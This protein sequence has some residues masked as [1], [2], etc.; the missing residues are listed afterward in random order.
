MARHLLE[1][2]DLFVASSGPGSASPGR[3]RLRTLVV[4]RWIAVIGQMFSLLLVRYGLG[5]ELPILPCAITVLASA[6]LNGI[7]AIQYPTTARLSN[8]GATL[9]LAYDLLQLCALLYMTG[10]LTNPFAILILVPVVISATILSAGSTFLLGAL[11]LLFSIL[12]AFWHLP[13]PWAPDRLDLP[14]LYRSAIWTGL[15]LGIV[16]MSVYAGRVAFETRRMSDALMATHEALARAQQLSA[17]GGLA[18]SAAHELGTP[19][20]TIHLVA[21][22]MA[23]DMPEDFEY[24]ED[25]ELLVTQAERC[26]GILKELSHSPG[27]GDDA[28]KL[29]TLTGLVE[30]A[31]EPY[32]A[33]GARIEV[34]PQTGHPP[35]VY[36]SPEVLHGLS[37]FVENAMDF[38]RSGVRVEIYWDQP[39]ITVFVDDDGPGIPLDVLKTLGEPY[40][41]SR[42]ET[43]GMGLGVFISKTLLEYSGARVQ[44][45]NRSENN[46]IAG[47]RV[48]IHWPRGI[49][50]PSRDSPGLGGA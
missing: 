10:G 13:L 43:G 29:T 4:V 7:L 39:E 27:D 41:T 47:A 19:L 25:L 21:K 9:F 42:P 15:A 14:V 30:A 44:F 50:D 23:R 2:E 34:L 5:F 18:A 6:V 1:E 3:V 49:I 26:R 36:R 20:G 37:N 38:A 46:R 17:V 8:R 12:L 24:R 40:R 32:R 16:F 33:F 22:E 28:F 48:A 35:T 31:V 45:A 11:A